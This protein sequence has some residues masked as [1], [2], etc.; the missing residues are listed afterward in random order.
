[1]ITTCN[2]DEFVGQRDPTVSLH[3]VVKDRETSM[4][5]LLDDV[6]EF[7]DEFHIVLVET[8]EAAEHE[9]KKRLLRYP[10]A[11][12]TI[13]R[14][15]PSTHPEFYI[16]DT[17]STYLDGSPLSDEILQGPF[18]H[19]P[20]LSDLG[21]IR[22]LCSQWSTCEWQ[23]HLEP[24]DWILSPSKIPMIIQLAVKH[25]ADAVSTN[26]FRELGIFST[27]PPRR[28]ILMRNCP[29]IRWTGRAQPHLKGHASQIDLEDILPISS[30]KRD[31]SDLD[32]N[33]RALYH[34][35][36]VLDW[37]VPSEH[38]ESLILTLV[39]MRNPPLSSRW[40]AEPLFDLYASKTAKLEELRVRLLV[41]SLYNTL[42]DLAN[43]SLHYEKALELNPHPL[44]FFVLSK[45]NFQLGQW[46]SCIE[47]YESGCR[48][49][50]DASP[51][52]KLEIA[53]LMLV[54]ISHLALGNTSKAQEAIDEVSKANM[55]NPHVAKVW[56]MI[57][58][59]TNPR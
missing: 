12:K 26:F 29:T 36:R 51:N 57:Y 37:N 30:R 6:A 10:W 25:G 17:P 43:A 14:I 47:H 46:S 5:R 28:Q 24:D 45:I 31:F 19:L 8:T 27:S 39:Q 7:M 38:L 21:A 59:T 33:C 40:I 42:D 35:S 23:L 18:S 11:K 3:V 34:E 58:T 2:K 41:G 53:T 44:I 13:Q 22:R 49:Q 56:R 1:M 9:I 15:S 48:A 20:L 54:A 55:N 50:H 16:S 4:I 32:Q 52:Y